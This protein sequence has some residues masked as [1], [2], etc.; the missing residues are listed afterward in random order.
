M[1]LFF[2]PCFCRWWHLQGFFMHYFVP[3]FYR[4][5]FLHEKLEGGTHQKSATLWQFLTLPVT[6]NLVKWHNKVYL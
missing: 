3:N 4:G 6:K 1:W 2:L 5:A